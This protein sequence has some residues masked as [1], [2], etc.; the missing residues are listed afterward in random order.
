[1]EPPTRRALLATGIGVAIP[2]CFRSEPADERDSPTSERTID[3][4]ASATSRSTDERERS[5]SERYDCRDANRPEPDVEAGIEHE[6]E[7]DG[8]TLVY[9]SV[10]SAKYPDPPDSTAEEAI[11]SF[12]R[13]HE[14]AFLQNE[15]VE[16]LGDE[17]TSFHVEFE[18]VEIVERRDGIVVVRVEANVTEEEIS[19]GPSAGHWTTESVYAVDETG[20]VRVEVDD[21]PV[22][23]A[24]P[25]ATPDP[26]E[27][28]DLLVCF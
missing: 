1:M 16:K 14:A 21:V 7:D 2:G 19:G 10:G 9:E 8:E 13:E 11:E 24:T 18:V 25:P 27:Y 6:Y 5:I 3:R 15:S 12:V 4:R 28:G 17:L 26:M 22:V 20:V 23:T